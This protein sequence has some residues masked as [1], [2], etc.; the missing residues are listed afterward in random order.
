[1]DSE[2]SGQR[3]QML[4]AVQMANPDT[5]GEHPFDLCA[6]LVLDLRMPDA[7]RQPAGEEL[8]VSG[9]EHPIPAHEGTY[10][11]SNR[12]G[13]GI[14]QREMDSG[15]EIRISLEQLN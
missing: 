2:Q 4:V 1:H 3:M 9:R 10:R 14:D 13:G 15:I 11:G 8:H 5:L 12:D 7:P 6:Q